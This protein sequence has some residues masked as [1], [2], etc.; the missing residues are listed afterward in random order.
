[1]R[2]KRLSRHGGIIAES[3]VYMQIMVT[4][5]LKKA[6]WTP[7][8]EKKSIPSAFPEFVELDLKTLTR[9]PNYIV[10]H[11]PAQRFLVF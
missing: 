4:P 3:H 8:A 5:K 9:R 1:M 6:V 7:N 10:L 2:R 11:K